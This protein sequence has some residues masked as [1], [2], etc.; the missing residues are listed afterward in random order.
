METIKQIN[1]VEGLEALKKDIERLTKMAKVA[2]GKLKEQDLSYIKEQM[3]DISRN[4]TRV[5]IRLTCAYS[6]NK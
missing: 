6:M 4:L 2:E 1:T 5:S 3:N